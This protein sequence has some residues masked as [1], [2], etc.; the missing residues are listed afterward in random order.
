MSLPRPHP[1]SLYL[2]SPN[3]VEVGGLQ[4]L[5]ACVTYTTAPRSP[6]DH[7]LLSSSFQEPLSSLSP[8]NH[9]WSPLVVNMGKTVTPSSPRPN[10][11]SWVTVGAVG[12]CSLLNPSPTVDGAGCFP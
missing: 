3:H 1:Q 7:K 4:V 8:K 12:N 2:R 9:L 10:G 11:S 6:S 5:A